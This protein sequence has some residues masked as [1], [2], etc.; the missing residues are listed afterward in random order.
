MSDCLYK[1]ALTKIPKVGP[2][3]A[4][5]LISYCGG[6]KEVFE[7]RKKELEKIPGVGDRIASLIVKKDYFEAAERELDF[8]ENQEI[9]PLFFLDN[10]YPSRLKHSGDAPIL[11]Y[12][13]GTVDLNHP[14][15][16]AIVGT[17]KPSFMG[18]ALCEELVEGLAAYDV[19][20]ISGL[21]Y[22][23]DVTAHKKCLDIGS[24]TLGIL[25]H[26]LKRIYPAQH[27]SI[28][29][30]MIENGGLLTEFASDVGPDRENFPMRNRIVAGMC[31]ALIVVETAIKGGSMITAQF[32]NEYNKDV[33]AVPGRVKD[34]HL[35]GCNHLIK[36]HKAALIESAKDV[37][38]IMRWEELDQKKEI[39]RQ[40]FVELTDQEKVVANLLK[41]SEEIGIDEL[42]HEAK[43][44]PSQVAS[45]LLS[46]E[47][48]GLVK[49]LP[50]KR[51]ILI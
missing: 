31:D 15:I 48:K 18:V 32:G 50:G 41:Q 43:L 51:Y 19:L 25:G 8:I 40:L 46:L 7:A 2:V 37:G 27:R 12:Y 17:R 21:A 44:N 29:R 30:Q 36:T 16:V 20:I 38:Y 49:P 24:S 23:I 26:G 45:L 35:Q 42:V 39:Q 6:I 47:F 11:L 1:I 22:G 34:T 33:F 4:R 5:N 9:T 13:K 28:A 3:T 14:R 10:A